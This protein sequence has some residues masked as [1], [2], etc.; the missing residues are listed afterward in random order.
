MARKLNNR[1]KTENQEIEYTEDNVAELLKCATDP[2]YFISN[3]VMVQ[4]PTKGAMPFKLYD[5][6]KKMVNTFHTERY[7][8]TLSARQTGK[9]FF[10]STMINTIEV[11]TGIKKLLL[12]ILDK[13]EYEKIFKQLQAL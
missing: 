11:P 10:Y 9:C 1:L 6:Q 7:S 5:Y 4:H 12:Y 3:Y 13:K 2:V 8:V